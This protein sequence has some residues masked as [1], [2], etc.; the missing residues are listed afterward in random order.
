MKK[1]WEALCDQVID[2]EGNI[3]GIC[4]G[5]GFSFSADYYKN[6]LGWVLNDTHGIGIVLLAGVEYMKL[7]KKYQ[8]LNDIDNV[9][10]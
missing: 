2:R 1:A 9:K 8:R 4:R 5:S 10:L 7:N 3:Y 6:D